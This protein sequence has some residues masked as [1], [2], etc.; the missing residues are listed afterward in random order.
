MTEK[1]D[2]VAVITGANQGIGAEIVRKFLSL[3][4]YVVGIDLEVSNLDQMKSA[5]HS[6]AQS[7]ALLPFRIVPR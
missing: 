2:Q 1:S 6:L 3:G 4:Y 7:L 5:P